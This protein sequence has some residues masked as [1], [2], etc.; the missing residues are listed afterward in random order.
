M[1]FASHVQLLGTP[2]TVKDNSPPGFSVMEFPRQEYWR[3]DTEPL[4][5]IPEPCSKFPLA[6]YFTYGNVS[7]HVTHS[8]HL[9]LSSPPHVHKSIHYVCFSIVAL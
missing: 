7:F 3:I 2:W 8:I 1:L 6:I 4:F 9:T 5:E